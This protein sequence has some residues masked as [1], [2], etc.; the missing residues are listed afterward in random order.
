VS[1]SSINITPSALKA[2]GTYYVYYKLRDEHGV[3]DQ[4]RITVNVLQKNRAPNAL[5]YAVSVTSGQTVY[6]TVRYANSDPDGDTLSLAVTSKPSNFTVTVSGSQLAITP[7]STVATGTYYVYYKLTDPD[8]LTDTGRVSVNVTRPAN[9]APNAID[10]YVETFTGNI[11]STRVIYANTD[12]DGDAVTIASVTSSYGMN[13]QISGS[14][15]VF[16]ATVVGTHTITY[17]LRDEHGAQDSAV[18]TVNA[19][20]SGGGFGFSMTGTSPTL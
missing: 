6:R 8:G 7:S 17:T 5:D 14:D 16:W 10:Q 1:G 18:I 3:T 12:P 13:T 4:G 19:Q 15:I 9:R 20:Y 2:P 11:E